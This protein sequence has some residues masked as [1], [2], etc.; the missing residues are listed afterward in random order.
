[1]YTYGTSKIVSAAC[2]FCAFGSG[3]D[4]DRDESNISSVPVLLS[5]FL[6]H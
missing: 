3:R 6:P 4:I 5:G 1:M 2:R